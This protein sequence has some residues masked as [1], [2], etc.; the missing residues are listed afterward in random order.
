MK[1]TDKEWGIKIE[2][3][4]DPTEEEL[5]SEY[6]PNVW[7]DV[8]KGRLNENIFAKWFIETNHLM[9]SNGVFYTRSG[10]TDE[11]GLKREIAESLE[12]VGINERIGARVKNLLEA[13]KC[14]CAVP[15]FRPDENLIPFANGDFHI[16]TRTFKP[17]EFAPVPYRLPIPLK[18]TI[19]TPV[20][21]MKWMEN[22]FDE[23]D[24]ETVLEYLAYCLVPT[25]A[26]QKA[27]FLVGEG[28]TGKSGIGTVLQS[29]FGK[30]VFSAPDTREIMENRFMIAELENKLVL[31]DDDLNTAA[32][33]NTGLY[34]K[35]ITNTLEIKAD[36]KYAKPFE[37]KPYVRMIACCNQ[38]IT[39]LHDSSE[40]F[41][42]R[43]LPVLVKPK[44]KDFV[45]D[46]SFYNKLKREGVVIA[47]VL[48]R[49]LFKLIERDWTLP[50]SDRTAAYMAQKRALDNPLPDFMKTCFEFGENMGGVATSEI[51]KV[52]EYWCR[53]NSYTQL[54]PRTLQM[55]LTDNS[56]AYGIEYSK[57]IKV[58]S[59]EVRGYSGMK[60]KPEW[61]FSGK[62]PLS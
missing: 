53:K 48:L 43:L 3:V 15:S 7:I 50:E 61:D 51:I 36:R 32:L 38:M 10:M 58:N 46:L 16:D 22:L 42:R 5:Y 28:G 34:K 47:Q 39:S 40:G 9:Y 19:E 23:G 59:I 20:Y 12:G 17:G 54:R 49:Y 14:H 44:D 55:W 2:A 29:V 62:I 33:E 52:Y 26:A 24:R 30:A 25:T 6:Q 13:I 57:H 8:K 35:L 1:I 21:F 41:L 37:F 56:A 18:N 45:P 4:E 60:I 11:D 31:Y 27:L